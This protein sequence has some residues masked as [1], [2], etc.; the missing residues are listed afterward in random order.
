MQPG[1]MPLHKDSTWAC[2]VEPFTTNQE[3]L[4][5]NYLALT[6]V[7]T[8]SSQ[9]I[10]EGILNLHDRCTGETCPFD[11]ELTFGG[12]LAGS[13]SGEVKVTYEREALAL[14]EGILT[15]RGGNWTNWKK[16]WFKLMPTGHLEYFMLSK[17]G[18]GA[19][20]KPLNRVQLEGA[21][22]GTD[23]RRVFCFSVETPGRTFYMSADSSTEMKEW[24]EALQPYAPARGGAK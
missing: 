2:S 7:D 16:R 18:G 17:Q 20:G 1:D 3:Y 12:F 21:R 23:D 15:K 24:M 8:F 11:I 14:K 10:G 22:I 5:T 6:L 9:P 4:E 13:L 19:T